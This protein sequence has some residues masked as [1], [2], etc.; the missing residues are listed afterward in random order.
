MV[1][2]SLD[3]VRI[4]AFG[5]IILKKSILGIVLVL[6]A[7]LVLGLG[8]KSAY[9]QQTGS[10][11]GLVYEDADDNLLFNPGDSP[12]PAVQFI[13]SGPSGTITVTTYG[14]GYY[15]V[16]DLLPGIYTVVPSPMMNGMN[17]SITSPTG[18]FPVEITAGHNSVFDIPFHRRCMK[19]SWQILWNVGENGLP[20]GTATI[21]LTLTNL[22]P[23]PVGWIYFNSLTS[24]VSASPN[25]IMLTNPIPGNGGTA[26]VPVTI[27]GAQPGQQVYFSISFHSPDL[28]YCCMDRVCFQ[29]PECDCFQEIR[30]EVICNPDGSYT[31]NFTLQNLTPYLITQVWTVGPIG[32][33]VTPIV[34][35]TNVPPGGFFNGQVTVSGNSLGGKPLCLTIMFYNGGNRC[36]TKPWCVDLPDCQLCDNRPAVCYAQRPIYNVQDNTGLGSYNGVEWAL[37]SGQSVAAV[38]CF[39]QN[40]DD[41]IFGYMNLGQYQCNPPSNAGGYVFGIDWI[42]SS[43]TNAP[44]PRGFHNGYMGNPSTTTVPA[45]CQWTLKYLGTVFAITFDDQGNAYVA[46]T[47]AYN[48]DYAPTILDFNSPGTSGRTHSA[49]PN[50]AVDRRLHG[51]I[52][53]I[54]NITGK[55]TIFNEDTTTGWNGVPSGKDPNITDDFSGVSGSLAH[56]EQGFPEIG[57]VTFDYD[58]R[59]IFATC[60]DDGKIYRYDMNGTKLNSFDPFTADA[61]ATYGDGFAGLGEILWA[62]KYHRGRLYFSRYVEDFDHPVA[63]NNEVW[64]IGID[65]TG[66]FVAPSAFEPRLELTTPDIFSSYTFPATATAPISD[67]TFTSEGL[68]PTTESKMVLAERGMGGLWQY[69]TTYLPNAHMIAHAQGVNRSFTNTWPHRARGLEYACNPDTMKWDLV[70]AIA[71]HPFFFNLGHPANGSANSAGG[72]DFDFDDRG[73]SGPN[74][75]NRV[76]FQADYMFN[77]GYWYGLQGLPLYGGDMYNSIVDDLNGISGTFD[78]TSGGDVEVPCADTH[79]RLTGRVIFQD[80][81]GSLGGI[82]VSARL[83]GPGHSSD[84]VGTLD[85]NGN[86][87][88]TPE[89]ADGTYN[90]YFMVTNNL[91]KKV[92]FTVTG[93]V[94]VIGDVHVLT[95]DINHDNE[96]SLADFDLMAPAYGSSIG[97]ANFDPEADLNGDGSVDLADFDLLANNFGLNGDPL[98]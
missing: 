23:W 69:G 46:Q 89:M 42:N 9:A 74:L 62:A 10:L 82:P 93:G 13:I 40:L 86:F 50:E 68:A 8:A 70:P 35:N 91:I 15:S 26:V 1:L 47:S 5:R 28:A 21:N 76:W 14:S 72:V 52:F 81:V 17:L 38:T 6:M 30:H 41:P 44:N 63:G 56:S 71:N 79:A 58:H 36:C 25:P 19:M 22:N 80:F 67:I 87:T 88:F 85:A 97:D 45:D 27:T 53:K 49:S 78:K 11:S 7:F 77:A 61:G 51:R 75:G 90:A 39:S 31:I 16:P 33:T 34:H 92:S 60:M 83:T 59:F 37:A 4:R 18:S 55:V 95:G 12:L 84:C 54:E 64:S 94:A 2:K 29:M 66:N 3:F 43:A 57:D 73:C 20:N 32:V 65:A 48:T 24:G 98:P 96:V